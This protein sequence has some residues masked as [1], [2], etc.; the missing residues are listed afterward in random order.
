METLYYTVIAVLTTY[1]LYR[2]LRIGH[3]PRGIPPGPPTVPILGN[4]HLVLLSL[5]FL[6]NPD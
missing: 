3:R 1:F 4:I 6:P 2:L 5:L